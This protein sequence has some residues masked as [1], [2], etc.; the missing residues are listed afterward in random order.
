MRTL[1][2]SWKIVAAWVA[3]ATVVV[4]ACG[5]GGSDDG[6]RIAE[7]EAQI[8]ELT[9]T[10]TAPSTTTTTIAKVEV[11]NVFGYDKDAAVALLAELGIPVEL[12]PTPS[13]EAEGTITTKIR[14]PEREIGK[15][16]VLEYAI[17]ITHTFTAYYEA[18]D[19]KWSSLPDGKC[20]HRDYDVREGQS[21]RLIGPDGTELSA[22]LISDGDGVVTDSRTDDTD[23]QVCQFVFEFPDVPEVA[24][25]T[26][27]TQT[28]SDFPAVSLA[29]MKENNWSTIWFVS[30]R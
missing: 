2:A 23:G 28:D 1:I 30:R 6:A 26:F 5:S 16:I 21:V 22:V 9:A 8:A 27:E 7:L 13:S 18:W 17:P 24:T 11:P 10:T 4:A 12:Q 20:E 19:N 15:V 14:V 25:Y 29:S 3:G